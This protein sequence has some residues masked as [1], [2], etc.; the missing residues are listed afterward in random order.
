[1]ITDLDYADDICLLAESRSEAKS[2]LS[3]VAEESSLVGPEDK[4][5]EDKSH[6]VMVHNLKTPQFY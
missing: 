6:G 4:L 2:M 5:L 3:K 1:M